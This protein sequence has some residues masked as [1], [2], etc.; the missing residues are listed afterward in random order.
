MG[1]HGPAD[2]SRQPAAQMSGAGARDP[3]TGIGAGLSL[4]PPWTDPGRAPVL[5]GKDGA[6]L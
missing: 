1:S 5:D 4:L 2:K 3:G 6:F